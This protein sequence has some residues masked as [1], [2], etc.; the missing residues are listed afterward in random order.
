MKRNND[1]VDHWE[2]MTP[3]ERKFEKE[4]GPGMD[5]VYWLLIIFA[6]IYYACK[7]IGAI[8]K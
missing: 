5:G 6:V 3:D 4:N 7:I 8:G 2:R 1:F